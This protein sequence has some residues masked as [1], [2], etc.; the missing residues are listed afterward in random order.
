MNKKKDRLKKKQ[1]EL[2]REARMQARKAG[3]GGGIAPWKIVVP[4]IALLFL[5]HCRFWHAEEEWLM[6][7][8]LTDI[9]YQ[10]LTGTI[11][12]IILVLGISC[13]MFY[14]YSR[15]KKPDKESGIKQLGRNLV[16][17]FIWGGIIGA[18]CTNVILVFLFWLNSC[19]TSEV[20]TCECEIVSTVVHNRKSG[21]TT[22][23]YS[24]SWLINHF[25]YR[26]VFIRD[27]RYKRLHVPMQ[28]VGE[29][30]CMPGYRLKIQLAEGWLGWGVVSKIYPMTPLNPRPQEDVIY[31][32]EENTGQLP[33]T[34]P[35]AQKQYTFRYTWRDLRI[36]AKL[37]NI[38]LR[39]TTHVSV[40]RYVDAAKDA[41]VW[42]LIV[43]DS[44]QLD[45]GRVILIHGETGEVLM[46]SY[47]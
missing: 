13:W 14:A 36:F 5:I 8:A 38:N 40:N 25:S 10:S 43:R 29:F 4:I 9:G 19:F 17:G 42:E 45:K 6:R 39:D 15:P 46:D 22:F 21:N 24:A 1:Q 41:P 32:K 44:I 37:R 26:E 31:V 30:G 12:I 2:R 23:R 7:T 28:K 34:V 47:E 35:K 3:E 18:L 33:D 20:K 16:Y 27:D 11:F